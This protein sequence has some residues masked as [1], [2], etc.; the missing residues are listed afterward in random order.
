MSEL[1]VSVG[2]LGK[3]VED[4]VFEGRNVEIAVVGNSMYPLFVS[5]RDKVTLSPVGKLKRKQIVF[6]KRTD[7]SYVL[8]RIVNVKRGY[9]LIS[10][11]NEREKE[12]VLPSQVIAVVTSFC[13]KGKRVGLNEAWYRIYSSLWCNLYGMRAFMLKIALKLRSP[14]KKRK[15]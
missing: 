15:K 2:Q 5:K 6:Y 12:K 10:G 11:D 4:A 14:G 7:G 3:L 13:R 8:H 9:L 1:N